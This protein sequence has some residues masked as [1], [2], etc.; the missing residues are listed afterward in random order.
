MTHALQFDQAKRFYDHLGS[1]VDWLKF[2][3]ASVVDRALRAAGLTRASSVLEFGCGSG[4]VAEKLLESELPA[5]ACYSGLDISTTMV[6]LTRRRLH[7][8]GDRAT[9]LQYDG[10]A[11]PFSGETFDAFFSSF[12]FDLLEPDYMAYVMREAHRVLRPG[13]RACITSMA[14]PTS[15]P[16]RVVTSLWTALW[17]VSPWLVG[18]CRPVDIAAAVD[19]DQWTVEHHEV[20][21]RL[22]MNSAILC[23]TR[24][25]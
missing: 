4:R 10:G 16:T 11:F 24:K 7:R 1:R 15:T 18:G 5:G 17:H 21:T 6:E 23:A 13:A 19:P 2:Y 14:G 3:E 22:G 12:V 8:F 20:V 9:A 25:G